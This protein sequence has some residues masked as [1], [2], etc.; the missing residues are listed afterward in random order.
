MSSEN[1]R[2]HLVPTHIQGRRR[3]GE[4][5]RNAE[6]FERKKKLEKKQEEGKL[7]APFLLT[8]FSLSSFQRQSLN[9]HL[10]LLFVGDKAKRP[11]EWRRRQNDRLSVFWNSPNPQTDAKPRHLN[12]RKGRKNEA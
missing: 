7:S 8:L 10:L 3:V 2:I 9:I 11:D 5:E 12:K 1:K 6:R 4:K